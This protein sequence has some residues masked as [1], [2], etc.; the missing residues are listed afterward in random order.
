MVTLKIN[1]NKTVI[2][3][4]NNNPNEIDEDEEYTDIFTE[5][6]Q[7]K[8]GIDA[9]GNEIDGC[10][11][12]V[13]CGWCDDPTP[14]SDCKREKTFGWLCEQCQEYLASRGERLKFLR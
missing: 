14:E 6:E 10:E 5:E 7:E 13:R 3:G 11:Q 1:T 2:I 4:M 8:L 9:H 12:W